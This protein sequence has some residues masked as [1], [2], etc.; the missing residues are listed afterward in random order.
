MIAALK[1]RRVALVAVPL[2]VAAA[3]ILTVSVGR[4]RNGTAARG[5]TAGA[6]AMA[7]MDMGGASMGE[8]GSAHLTADQIRRFGITFDVVER[9]PLEEELRAAGVVRFDE[10][11]VVGVTAKFGGYVERLHVD[12]T[13]EPVRRGQPLVEIYSPELVA[14]QEELLLAARL[15]ETLGESAV[16]GVT[17]GTSELVGAARRRLRLWDISE[18]QIEQILRAGRASRTL[19]L[20]A[21][22][23]GIVVE[24][25]VIAGTAIQAGEP[26]YT[27]ADLSEVWIEA[28]IREADAGLVR[29]GAPASFELAAYPGRTFTGR[30]EYVYPA[31]QEQARTLRVRIAVPNR[32][33]RIKPGMYAT[34]R[35]TSPAHTALAVPAA[36]VVRTGE[37]SLVFVDM[38]DGM[39]MPHDVEIGRVAGDYAEVLAGVEPGQRVVTS[40]QFILDSESNLAEVMK[41]MLTTM[42]PSG[43]ERMDHSDHG[44]GPS[45]QR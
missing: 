28:E 7:G 42:D 29:E 37:R 19:T 43:T 24:K 3:V 27:I 26:L 34:V 14:A 38:G 6:D 1:E 23:S 31:L 9:R 2:A 25:N 36:A 12:Y 4:D 8:D 33:G 41:S 16:P 5:E 44:P 39:L 21:P 17:P 15:D 35:L 18:A 11:R 40:A 45:T 32:E 30:V 20:Y 13:G 22:A 10:T